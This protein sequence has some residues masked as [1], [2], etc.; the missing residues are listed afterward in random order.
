M[1]KLRFMLPMAVLSS[2]ILAISVSLPASAAIKA[3]LSGQLI[4]VGT[5]TDARGTPEPNATVRLY[6]WPSDTVLQGLRLGQKVPTTL[7]ATATTS[8]QGTYSFRVPQATL[9]SVAAS[10]GIANLEA[11]SGSSSWFFTRKASGPATATRVNLAV[12]KIGPTCTPWIYQNQLKRAW[13][14]VGQSYDPHATHVTQGFT[15]GAGQ[16]STLG[17]GFSTSN[18]VGSFSADGTDS[19][20]SE[21]GQS[22]PS[23]GV[24]N[25]LYRTQFREA[26]Y[27]RSCESGGYRYLVRSNGWAGGEK[28]FHP[29]RAP[30][31]PT[32]TCEP[33]LKGSSFYTHHERAVTWSTGLTVVAVGFDGQAQTG[34]S[35]S[36]QVTYTFH[37]DHEVCGTNSV[38][39]QAPQTIVRQ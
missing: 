20:S 16:S 4:A 6:A 34:Y 27:R 37:A 15:Y 9:S 33:Y 19:V 18:K 2:L 17:V 25:V 30:K 14:T 7:M 38:P 24:S 10:S 22:F 26:R 11:D 28:I 35:T 3:E 39:V 13:A 29:A 8:S 12:P 23:F 21:A 31:Y 32:W 36:A 5:V 1:R